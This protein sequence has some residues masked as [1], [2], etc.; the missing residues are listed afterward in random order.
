MKLVFKNKHLIGTVIGTAIFL[1]LFTVISPLIYL[2]IKPNSGDSSFWTNYWTAIPVIVTGLFAIISFSYQYQDKQTR[3]DEDLKKQRKLEKEKEK[4]E[5]EKE[6]A[7]KYN[8]Y[9]VQ[10]EKIQNEL[11]PKI[12][13]F[14]PEIRS[15]KNKSQLT[16]DLIILITT[17]MSLD[18]DTNPYSTYNTDDSR[19]ADYLAEFKAKIGI[20]LNDPINKDIVKC[21]SNSYSLLNQWILS[22]KENYIA[23]QNLDSTIEPDDSGTKMTNKDQRILSAWVLSYSNAKKGKYLIGVSSSNKRIVGIYKLNGTP[24]L[25]NQ[26]HRVK[27]DGEGTTRIYLEGETQIKNDWLEQKNTMPGLDNWTAQNPVLYY[28]AYLENKNISLSEGEKKHI[29]ES[30]GISINSYENLTKRD[31]ILVRTFKFDL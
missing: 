24:T 22:E 6:R 19:N 2:Y 13:S 14:S 25:N 4:A 3:Q 26:N 8:S 30:L 20:I 21:V 28:K 12:A 5:K 1:I 9:L 31:I 11:V 10:Q 29:S 27:F 18:A 7:E 16:K 23:E 15:T 17:V